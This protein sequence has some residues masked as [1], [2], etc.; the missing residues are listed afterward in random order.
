MKHESRFKTLILSEVILILKEK[1][2]ALLESSRQHSTN[3]QKEILEQVGISRLSVTD[4]TLEFDRNWFEFP[5]PFVQV[6]FHL[7]R[8]AL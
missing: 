2:Q 6:S 1:E 7:I 8:M 4:M 3:S 5:N